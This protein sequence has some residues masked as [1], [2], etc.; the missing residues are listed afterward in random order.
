LPVR[1]EAAALAQVEVRRLRSGL[2]QPKRSPE[3][4][5]LVSTDRS[6]HLPGQ[7]GGA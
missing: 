3:A 4:P 1:E 7:E 2:R 5:T 6:Q